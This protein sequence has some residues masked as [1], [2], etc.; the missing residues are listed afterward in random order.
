MSATK[1]AKRMSTAGELAEACSRLLLGQEVVVRC[2]RESSKPQTQ[3]VRYNLRQPH[4]KTVVSSQAAPAA[5]MPDLAT[6][7]GTA[8]TMPSD[9]DTSDKYPTPAD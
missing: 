9:Q 5:S 4:Q 1:A 2:R 8:A 3:L 7:S 6:G